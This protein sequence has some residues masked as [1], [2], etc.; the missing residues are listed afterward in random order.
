VFA[1]ASSCDALLNSPA[2]E[3]CPLGN[4]LDRKSP[5]HL[6]KPQRFN[7]FNHAGDV[8]RPLATKHKRVFRRLPD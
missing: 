6:I 2:R 4:F 8:N 3:A 7:G 1:P 5:A